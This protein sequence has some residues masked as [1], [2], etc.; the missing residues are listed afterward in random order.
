MQMKPLPCLES[1]MGW[2][3]RQAELAQSSGLT[4]DYITVGT[5]A[6]HVSC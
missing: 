4:P 3:S 5:L 6:R 2:T 1:V